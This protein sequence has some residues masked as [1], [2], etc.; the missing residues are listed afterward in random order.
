MAF[1]RELGCDEYQGYYFSKPVPLADLLAPICPRDQMLLA[2]IGAG[3]GVAAT[4]ARRAMT[5]S[6]SSGWTKAPAG[7]PT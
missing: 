6:R 4:A 3:L 5:L 2:H 7:C 1:L